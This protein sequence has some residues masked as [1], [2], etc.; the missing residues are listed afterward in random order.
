L[1]TL[2]T[3]VSIAGVTVKVVLLSLALLKLLSPA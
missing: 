3:A 2:T 1:F